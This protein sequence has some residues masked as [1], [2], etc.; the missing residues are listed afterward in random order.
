[1][2]EN[3]IVTAVLDEAIMLHKKLGPGLLES[4][5]EAALSYELR[6]KGFEIKQQAFMPFEYKKIVLNKS[7]VADIMVNDLVI[8]EIKSQKTNQEIHRMQLLS[9]LRISRK[10]LGLVLNF[11]MEL[12]IDG[13]SRVANGL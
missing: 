1:M 6:E 9:Y 7:F 11:G 8:L 10:K 12:M 3:Q 5:Y 2:N 13:I 4:V